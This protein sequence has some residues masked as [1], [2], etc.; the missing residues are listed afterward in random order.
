MTFATNQNLPASYVK[1]T[2]AVAIDTNAPAA[3]NGQEANTVLLWGEQLS[4]GIA[5]A[6]VPNVLGSLNDAINFYG[7][8]SPITRMLR[9]ALSQDGVTG[10]VRFVGVGVA[11]ASG[12]TLATAQIVASIF[13]S[14]WA[15][16]TNPAAAGGATFTLGGTELASISWT[17]TDTATTIGA[18]L[19]TALNALVFCPFT[20]WSNSS[21]TVTSTGNMKGAALE[22]YPIRVT[23]SNP[24]SGV[25]F[26][27]GALTLSG[28]PGAA[29]S[30]SL[31]VGAS[32]VVT[33]IS[34][35][36]S[37]AN[38]AAV[39]VQAAINAATF[40]L[41]APA[42]P[43][44]GVLPLLFVPGVDYRRASCTITTVTTTTVQ[45]LNGTAEGQGST[46]P[47]TY[48]GAVGA[49]APSLATAVGNVRASGGFGK[50]VSP[51]LDA[52]S[53][54]AL[55]G[56]I[57]TDGDGGPGHN[58]GQTLTAVSVQSETS[59]ASI[60]GSVSPAMNANAANNNNA[61]RGAV[62]VC[63]DAAQP[64]AELAAR[65]A[66]LR[67][68]SDPFTNYDGLPLT[69]TADVPVLL[70]SPLAVA[71]FTDSA[72]NQAILDG[73]T[74]LA[75]QNGSLCIVFGRTTIATPEPVLWDWSWIDQADQHRRDL[76]AQAQPTFSGCALITQGTVPKS[77]KDVDPQALV[78]FLQAQLRRWEAQGTYDGAAALSAQCQAQINPSQRS[79]AD[80]VYP[81]SPKIPLHTLGVVAQRQSPPLT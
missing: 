23:Y 40:P 38:A 51:W 79:R 42:A 47:T 9:A 74:P 48:A 30:I 3:A 24:S 33:A 1:P 66:A 49:G 58:K 45:L 75:V 56:A 19:A 34:G 53:L 73:L 41:F 25:Y 37:N 8:R 76:I 69:G 15:T 61:L 77:R 17:T 54:G 29:G 32:T 18:A 28:T 70:P 62:C 4:G 63:P 43:S 78:A 50:W 44:A 16:A 36:E 35:T 67:A 22:D 64:G 31:A 65:V 20:S 5:T 2:I 57:T 39:E 55:Y 7:Q 21:G 27:P 26:G 46:P 13:T 14:S 80:L 71:S 52:T 60:P 11:P 68:S 10:A 72:Q 12:G 6:N 59:T 81:E